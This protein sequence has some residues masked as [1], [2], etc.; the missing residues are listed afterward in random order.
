MFT[1]ALNRGNYNKR[2][3]CTVGFHRPVV[4]ACCLEEV[5]RYCS[6]PY[7]SAGSAVGSK[8]RLEVQRQW[9]CI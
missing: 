7:Y 3:C 9:L 5:K 2:Y 4:Q 1:K 8:R 6:K